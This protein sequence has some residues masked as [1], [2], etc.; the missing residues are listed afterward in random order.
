MT[1]TIIWQIHM[2]ALLA[3]AKGFRPT[4]SMRQIAGIVTATLIIPVTP[5]ARSA[6]VAFW[7]PRDAKMTE[8]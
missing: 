8:A 1:P 3:K 4:L 7:R 5:E 2:P 6:A